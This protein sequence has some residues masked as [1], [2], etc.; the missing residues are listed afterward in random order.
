MSGTPFDSVRDYIDALERRGRLL[1]LPAMDQDRYEASAFAYRLIERFGIEQAPAFL[2][3]RVKE[4]GW[5]R[6]D[7]QD[8]GKSGG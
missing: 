3:E 1:R 4:G 8:F 7:A 5:H 2:I 6:G